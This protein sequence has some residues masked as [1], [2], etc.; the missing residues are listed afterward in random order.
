M[1]Q[2]L[3]VGYNLQDHMAMSTLA[4]LVNESVTVSDLR[5]QNPRDI[6][7]YIVNGK[8]PFTIPGGAEALAFV[9]TKYSTNLFDDYPDIELVLGGGALNGDIF[10]S[11][12]NLLGIPDEVFIKVY[13]SILNVPA[14]GIAPV[15]MRPKSRGR[16]LIKDGNPLHWPILKPDYFSHPDDVSVL[17]EGIKMVSII[18]LFRF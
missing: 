4:F 11:L 9:K 17:V 10:G 12:R 3:K 5:V 1:I 16:V 6:F 15:L 18:Y 14:F 2:D 8:G 13:G 7:N